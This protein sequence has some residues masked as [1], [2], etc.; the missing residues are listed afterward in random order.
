MALLKV[1]SEP[2]GLRVTG[3]WPG[4]NYT[5]YSREVLVGSQQYVYVYDPTNYPHGP[6][7]VN[8][9]G[10]RIYHLDVIFPASPPYLDSL[11][12]VT[13]TDDGPIITST[14]LSVNPLSCQEPCNIDISAT[15][16][17]TGLSTRSFIPSIV[18]DGIKTSLA[19]ESL[20]AG[21]SITKTFTKTGLIL[22]SH[23]VCPD[24]N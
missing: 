11:I 3:G 18:V 17:N 6:Y 4:T 20:P 23:S 8:I 12:T 7:W 13:I 19:S 2:S 1:T 10:D 21:A 14:N 16:Q 22:G 5:P 9:I 15:W 24:P